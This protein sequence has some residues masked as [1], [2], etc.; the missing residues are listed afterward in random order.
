V[1]KALMMAEEMVDGS[2]LTDGL[3]DDDDANE[4]TGER[5]DEMYAL[6]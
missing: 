2:M 1:R 4:E 5:S 6:R 3:G